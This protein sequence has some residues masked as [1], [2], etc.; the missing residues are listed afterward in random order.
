MQPDTCLTNVRIIVAFAEDGEMVAMTTKE[1]GD[2][3]ETKVAECYE[4]LGYS[5]TRH[6]PVNGQEVD[7]VATMSIAGTAPYV[8]LIECK[9]HEK[10]NAS[11]DDVQ[12]IAGAFHI[13]L[14]TKSASACTLVSTNGFTLDARRA[15]EAAGIHLITFHELSQRAS[16]LPPHLI[17]E[18]S[19]EISGLAKRTPAQ[20]SGDGQSYP[21]RR[22]IPN[23]IDAIHSKIITSERVSVLILGGMGSGKST[24][25]I[26]LAKRLVDDYLAGKPGPF[27]IYIPLERYTSW[28]EGG[29]FDHFISSYLRDQFAA[30]NVGWAT[31]KEWLTDNRVVLICDGFDE[32]QKMTSLRHTWTTFHHI[33]EVV[34][35]E[36]SI[37]VSCRTSLMGDLALANDDDNNV[38][39]M[40]LSSGMP[41]CLELV[42]FSTLQVS[43]YLERRSAAPF[44]QKVLKTQ[45]MEEIARR[46]FL[47]RLIVDTLEEDP[48]DPQWAESNLLDFVID[49]LLRYKMNLRRG[50]LRRTEWRFFLEEAALAM[51]LTNSRSLSREQLTLLLVEHFGQILPDALLAD[52]DCDAR[53]RTVFDIDL[54]SSH[55]MFRYTHAEFR[56][57]LC[58][59]AIAR[60]LL[61]PRDEDKRLDGFRLDHLLV[62]FVQHAISKLHSSK[63]ESL[64]SYR[65]P[66]N[67]PPQISDTNEWCWIAPGLSIVGPHSKNSSAALVF[68]K[69]GYWISARP[70]RKGDVPYLNNSR[71]IRA[72]V[73]RKGNEHLEPITKVTNAIA[74]QMASDLGGRLPTEVEWERACRWVDGSYPPIYEKPSP[75]RKW[76]SPPLLAGGRGNPWGVKNVS[77]G[78]WQWTSTLA[79]GGRIQICK[80]A[81]WGASDADYLNSALRL[82][83]TEFE[84]QRTGFRIVCDPTNRGWQ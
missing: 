23:V 84:H 44:L 71:P 7:I 24:L 61:S 81:W 43:E 51:S 40:G 25:L 73:V 49:G 3:F 21:E 57:F 30:G 26:Q 62:K 46:P 9:Y 11:N 60:R 53:V 82:I 48:N 37:V 74:T 13:A 6:V 8:V 45:K 27:P 22:S 78:V 65:R 56:D 80:G 42:P 52:V 41:M 5:V 16:K 15:A 28:A 2:A 10:R 38:N 58:A 69:N 83:P 50:V 19:E 20:I 12:S 17:R 63:H 76:S 55:D 72:D 31:V 35:G 66:E 4:R 67:P 36:F 29:Y 47:L 18:M 14:A 79:D 39:G 32:I 34:S 70:L 59:H 1:R 54:A 68:V 64:R 77:G 33:M 75:N